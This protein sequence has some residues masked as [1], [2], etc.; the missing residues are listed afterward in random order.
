MT[1]SD[2]QRKLHGLLILA[3]TTGGLLAWSLR[4]SSSV[5]E[6]PF[7]LLALLAVSI[8]VRTSL[9]VPKLGIQILV[10]EGLVFL[11]LLLFN[12]EAAVL[13]AVLTAGCATLHGKPKIKT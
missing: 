6:F 13:L 7:L 3:L 9:K 10:S 4:F 1:V 12:G 11:G 5:L 2:N 8:G